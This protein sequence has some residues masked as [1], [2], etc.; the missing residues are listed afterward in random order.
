M[1]HDMNIFMGH[2]MNIFIS[3]KDKWMVVS[4]YYISLIS[5]NSS[6]YGFWLNLTPQKDILCLNFENQ[7]YSTSFNFYGL[8]LIQ[9]CRHGHCWWRLT[10]WECSSTYTCPPQLL[11]SSSYIFPISGQ[12][13][14][15]SNCGQLFLQVTP[16]SEA[17]DA[18]RQIVSQFILLVS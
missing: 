16:A 12:V 3:S 10:L 14:L 6:L 11:W 8:N 15:F 2:G 17:G 9:G 7:I 18:E 4:L 1:G 5:Q 13:Q